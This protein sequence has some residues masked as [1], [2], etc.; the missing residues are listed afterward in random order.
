MI[1]QMIG[2]VPI[3]RIEEMCGPF[4]PPDVLL[5]DLPDGALEEH[6]GWLKTMRTS[7]PRFKGLLQTV[8]IV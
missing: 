4:F 3:T 6:A 5:P 1:T 7:L 2:A 8:N